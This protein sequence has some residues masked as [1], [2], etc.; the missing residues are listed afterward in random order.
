MLIKYCLVFLSCFVVTKAF[1]QDDTLKNYNKALAQLQVLLP[2]F[3][4]V[5]INQVA[6]C[7]NNHKIYK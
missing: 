7:R 1:C 2:F 5:Y 6:H 3:F 4:S